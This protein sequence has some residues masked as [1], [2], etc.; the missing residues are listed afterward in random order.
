MGPRRRLRPH[1]RRA[2]G[3]GPTVVGR[4]GRDLRWLL[5][6]LHGPVRTRRGAWTVARGRGPVWGLRDR[7][8]L[9]T[10]RPPRPAR[11]PADDGDAGGPKPRRGLSARIAG[12]SGRADRGA[13]A[14]PPRPQGQ[15]RRATH[16][17]ADGRGARD[18]RQDPR[19]PLVR[20]G[21]PRVGAPGEPPRRLRAD[22]QVPADARPR[23]AARFR[24]GA[25]GSLHRFRAILGFAL[26]R[27]RDHADGT[28]RLEDGDFDVLDPLQ[29]VRTH[30]R[31]DLVGVDALAP[32]RLS[33]DPAIADEKTWLTRDRPAQERQPGREGLE[34]D[35]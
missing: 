7:R 30:G 1:R 8:E 3:A 29:A 17:R 33:E 28:V 27:L 35:V 23:R 24:P 16:D 14:H 21:R 2:L 6:R 15:A 34:P 10:R 22:P 5:W 32:E 19:G 18:R 31:L 12:L 26:L 13:P 20:R 11:S 4:A 9:P 25:L